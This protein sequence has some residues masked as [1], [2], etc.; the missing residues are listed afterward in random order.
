MHLRLY[1]GRTPNA[2]I[3][4]SSRA[5]DVLIS[6]YLILFSIIY[7]KGMASWR[8]LERN[9]M[10]WHGIWKLCA[11]GQVTLSV[12]PV[13]APSSVTPVPQPY[14]LAGEGLERAG[15]LAAISHSVLQSFILWPFL[16]NP[17]ERFMFCVVLPTGCS[18]MVGGG[19]GP[20]NQALPP[21]GDLN[22]LVE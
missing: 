1:V 9:G 7:R 6:C 4:D 10:V 19:A 11:G 14:G 12:V 8:I 17:A 5:L 3:M 18:L 15:T 21:W 2:F 16:L 20:H 13:T 22:K